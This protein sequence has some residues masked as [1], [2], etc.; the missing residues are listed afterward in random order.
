MME[1]WDARRRHL[2]TMMPWI[3]RRQ[4]GSPHRPRGRRRRS[5]A[6]SFREQD[7]LPG[8]VKGAEDLVRYAYVIGLVQPDLVIETGTYHGGSARFFAAF[9]C[10]VLTSDP[11]NEDDRVEGR[12]ELL[13]GS[14]T[15]RRVID[16]SRG[17][18]AWPPL[19]ARV[20]RLRSRGAHV[21]VEI[22]A[23]SPL[24]TAGS[25]LVVEDG[26][27]SYLPGEHG[28]RGSPLDAIETFLE[29]GGSDQFEVDADVEGMFPVTMFPKGWLRRK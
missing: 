23:Y 12:I 9:G 3:R 21:V 25:Y 5:I 15:D 26:I 29:A 2:R 4:R 10:E 13:A 19:S 16:R 17:A 27:V 22:E 20:A 6:R 18:G 14:S 28:Y 7:V 11:L 24:V 8:V 1:G